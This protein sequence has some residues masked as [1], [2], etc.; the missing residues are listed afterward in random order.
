MSALLADRAAFCR[1]RADAIEKKF[2]N[3]PLKL[4]NYNLVVRYNII[5]D[6]VMFVVMAA[7]K[8]ASEVPREHVVCV[9]D[10]TSQ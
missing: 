9:C 2:S 1:R 6:K 7:D 5:D 8:R 3:E 10:I 4:W